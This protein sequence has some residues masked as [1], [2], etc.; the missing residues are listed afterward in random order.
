MVYL[1]KFKKSIR[2]RGPL[3]TF[4]HGVRFAIQDPGYPVF[5]KIMS[6]KMHEKISAA[7]VLGYWPELDDPRSFSEK[8]I[9]RKL[10]TENTSLFSKLSDKY[11]VREYVEQK[12]GSE[13]L[14]DL[15][16][17]GDDPDE[18]PFPDLPNQFVIK[19]THGSAMTIVVN[20]KNRIDIDSIVSQCKSWLE[21]PYGKKSREY[22]YEQISPRIIV[23]E[24]IDD[25]DHNVPPDF[26]FYVFNGRVEYVHV[27]FNRYSDNR[28]RRFFDR[29]WNPCPFQLDFPLGPIIDE[30]TR[31]DEMINIAE[32]LGDGLDFARVDLYHTSDNNLYFGEITLAPGAGSEKF[33]P[34][35]WDFKLGSYW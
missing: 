24:Y 14:T 18:I 32:K 5:S 1:D 12:M 4:R 10:A 23:E 20:N 31:I 7:P 15:Y 11:A 13:I 33:Y 28:A 27:D 34:T 6:A 2:N 21:T 9:L 3:L 25:P 22:W 17:V 8:T 35:E 29:E 26:K 30:P 19:A 16:F